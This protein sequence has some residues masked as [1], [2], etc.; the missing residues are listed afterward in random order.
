LLY[1]L[2]YGISPFYAPKKED[3]FMAIMNLEPKFPK[4]PQV[5]K[6]VK[7]LIKGLI[8]KDPDRRIGSL[9]GVEEIKSHPWMRVAK[10]QEPSE[11]LS[12]P[13]Q[14]LKISAKE[15]REIKESFKVDL[16]EEGCKK[17]FFPK[18]FVNKKLIDELSEGMVVFPRRKERVEK[19]VKSR[20]R[21]RTHGK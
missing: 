16:G 14:S 18:S 4:E 19:M 15:V 10:V 5:S 2:L 3:I 7:D 8:A 12:F 13:F 17:C 9:K 21:N 1:E 6:E 11:T 20:S